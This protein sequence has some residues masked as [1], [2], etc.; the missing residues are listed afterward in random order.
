MLKIFQKSCAPITDGLYMRGV[1]RVGCAEG[2]LTISNGLKQ[3][4]ASR[5]GCVVDGSMVLMGRCGSSYRPSR[6]DEIG[7]VSYRLLVMFACDIAVCIFC[8]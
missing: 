3:L 2:F 7:W 1:P 5:F 6:F 8:I 4:L